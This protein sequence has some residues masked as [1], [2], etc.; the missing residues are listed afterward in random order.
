MF[1]VKIFSGLIWPKN[2]FYSPFQW[3]I[4]FL[5]DLEKS[6]HKNASYNYKGA[7]PKI[8]RLS[9]QRRTRYFV[10]SSNN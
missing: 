3:V 8:E 1:S 10:S 6:E 5:T 4:K 2:F 7:V 9:D